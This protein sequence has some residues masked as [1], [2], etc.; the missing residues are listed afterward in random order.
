M[1]PERLMKLFDKIDSGENVYTSE[2][3]VT[4]YYSDEE[5]IFAKIVNN[6]HKDRENVALN[7][8]AI[9]A[10]IRG[11]TIGC[12]GSSVMQNKVK[13]KFNS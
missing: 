5:R 7:I 1:Q 2:S 9:A 13:I 11:V 4:N 3:F 10:N 8:L 12:F 6:A